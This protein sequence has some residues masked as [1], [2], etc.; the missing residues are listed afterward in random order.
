M[1]KHL[2]EFYTTNKT[3]LIINQVQIIDAKQFLIV[4]LDTNNKIFIIYD[5][6]SK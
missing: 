6:I 3:L 1:I 2:Y 5:A 4:A